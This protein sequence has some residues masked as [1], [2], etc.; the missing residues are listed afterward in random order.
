MYI[1]LMPCLWIEYRGVAAN[2][3]Q[4]QQLRH[5]H[6]K[7]AAPSDVC[8][9]HLGLRICCEIVIVIG[10]VAH[11]SDGETQCI[12]CKP[13][14]GLV[15]IVIMMT[16]HGTAMGAAKPSS[17]GLLHRF[18]LLTAQIQPHLAHQLTVD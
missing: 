7:T 18:C 16:K 13:K 17:F 8:E 3:N 11:G 15:F 4:G 14:G 1:M 5:W 12:R 10:V 2:I 6:V 9:R